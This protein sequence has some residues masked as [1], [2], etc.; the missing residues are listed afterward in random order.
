[1][2]TRRSFFGAVAALVVGGG[3]A[4]LRL[5]PEPGTWASIERSTFPFWRA[6]VPTST[7]ALSPEVFRAI[8]DRCSR[9]D[10]DTILELR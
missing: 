10:G 2:I 6:Q 9:D 4:R 5:T 7:A 3:A 8:Y 1:M